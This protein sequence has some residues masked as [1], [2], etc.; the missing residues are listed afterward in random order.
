MCTLQRS[1]LAHLAERL[2]GSR[3]DVV[4]EFLGELLE[5]RAQAPDERDVVALGALAALPFRDDAAT[6][7]GDL[8]RRLPVGEALG[9]AERADFVAARRSVTGVEPATPGLGVRIGHHQ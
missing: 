1:R 6:A 9:P 7:V 8:T 4:S 3:E 2:D 5:Q